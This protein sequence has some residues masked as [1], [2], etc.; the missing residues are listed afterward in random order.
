MNKNTF[1]Y[2]VIIALVVPLLGYA[3]WMG[4]N[5]GL[6]L[7]NVLDKSGEVFQ[8]SQKTIVLVAVCFNLIPFHHAKNKRL[9]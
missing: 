3:L 7:S 1:L 6:K 9:E 4:I 2:G 8:F 5:F